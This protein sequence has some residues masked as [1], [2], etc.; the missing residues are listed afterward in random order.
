MNVLYE[1][2]EGRRIPAL[3]LIRLAD[4]VM[5]R[6]LLTIAPTPT[7]PLTVPVASTSRPKLAPAAHAAPHQ[8]LA[9]WVLNNKSALS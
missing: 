9:S 2:S 1:P 8:S 7:A 4:S 5:S 6:R 3:V